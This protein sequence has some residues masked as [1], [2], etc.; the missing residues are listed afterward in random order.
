M[1]AFLFALVG[2]AAG[3]VFCFLVLRLSRNDAFS[4]S[5]LLLIPVEMGVFMA[6]ALLLGRGLGYMDF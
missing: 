3:L 2:A 6:F 4:F 5:V 1:I